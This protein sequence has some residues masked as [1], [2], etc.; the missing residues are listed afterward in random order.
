MFFVRND[1]NV[2]FHN[3][4]SSLK[5]SY[6]LNECMNEWLFNEI[7]GPVLIDRCFGLSHAAGW[8]WLPLLLLLC[9][10]TMFW[11]QQV[12]RRQRARVQTNSELQRVSDGWWVFM[13]TKRRRVILN[14]PNTSFDEDTTCQLQSVNARHTRPTAASDIMKVVH[15][16]MLLPDEKVSESKQLNR[17]QKRAC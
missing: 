2:L 1:V 13:G 11:P 4:G 17:V 9:Q 15:L 7:V 12:E 6:L 10:M 3:I 14:G 5:C 8:P 16:K